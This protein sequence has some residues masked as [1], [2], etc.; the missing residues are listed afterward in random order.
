MNRV[1]ASFLAVSVTS[2]C[3]LVAGCGSE[4]PGSVGTGPS[5]SAPAQAQAQLIVPATG[6]SLAHGIAT[7]TVYVEEGTM[8]AVGADTQGNQLDAVRIV[9]DATSTTID[10]L[11][12]G[13]T[14]SVDQNG[15]VVENTLADAN[16][17]SAVLTD[18]HADVT[19]YQTVHADA[20][21]YACEWELGEALATC[22][23]V[24]PICVGT[25]GL[26]CV[27]AGLACERAG[28][29]AL[30]CLNQAPASQ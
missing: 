28:S 18:L 19:A 6:S 15:N 23:L 25:G 14:F 2:G 16:R 17:T 1:L 26:G 20:I 13:G 11:A 8:R 29:A 30:R 7:W 24:Y 5:T 9:T 10:D 21:G 12:A 4:S 22:S 3:L 27:A